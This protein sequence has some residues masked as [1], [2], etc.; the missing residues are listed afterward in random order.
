MRLC[1]KCGSELSENAKFCKLCGTPTEQ[2][3]SVP[4][5]MSLPQLFSAH[6]VKFIIGAAAAVVLLL[7]IVLLSG[8]CKYSGCDNRSVSGS[9]YCY[10]HKCNLCEEKKFPYSNYCYN[11]YL[12]YDEDAAASSMKSDLRFSKITITNNSSY[13]VA[14]GS[15]T[16]YGSKTYDYVKIKGSFKTSSGSVVDTDW[17]YAVGGEG[18]APGESST[19]RLSVDK[20]YSITS[21]SVSIMD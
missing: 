14:T 17:T 7:L 15:V 5:Q 10:S 13:T 18:L 1:K 9:K 3:Q 12:L 20:D 16:N 2:P 21:C 4:A 6:K 11:H 8:G 19:F